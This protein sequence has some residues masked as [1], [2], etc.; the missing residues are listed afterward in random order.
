MK[1]VSIIASFEALTDH[2]AKLV[3]EAARAAIEQI[4][5][6]DSVFINWLDKP[7]PEGLKPSLKVVE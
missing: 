6:P 5:N 7:L 3:A 4:A 1:T 2:D